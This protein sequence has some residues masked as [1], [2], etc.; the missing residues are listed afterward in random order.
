MNFKAD[1]ANQYQLAT[2]GSWY[3]DYVLTVNKTVSYNADGSADAYLAGQYD[4]WSKNW[5]A[6]PNKTYTVE[7]NEPVKVM[8]S[9][10][11]IYGKPGLKYTY[12]EVYETVKDFDC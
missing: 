2:Y 5:L 7:A 4:S 12:K 8:E 6:V 3:A 11:A 9:A 1:E 10:A